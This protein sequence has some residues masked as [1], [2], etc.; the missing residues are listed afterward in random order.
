M[1]WHSPGGRS[2]PQPKGDPTRNTPENPS[3]CVCGHPVLN[4]MVVY[5]WPAP[6]EVKPFLVEPR[7]MVREPFDNERQHKGDVWAMDPKT[8]KCGWYS[9]PTEANAD[10]AITV[11]VR[12]FCSAQKTKRKGKPRPARR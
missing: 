5:E 10:E 7:T 11:Y 8:G 12:H 4:A 9:A 2:R 6:S 3:R 1:G